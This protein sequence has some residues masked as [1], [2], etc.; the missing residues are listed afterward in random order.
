MTVDPDYPADHSTCRPLPVP[1]CL[2]AA[3]Q[4]DSST[5]PTARLTRRRHVVLR[6]APTGSSFHSRRR[7]L[8]PE[9]HS[10]GEERARSCSSAVPSAPLPRR[11]TRVSCPI[12][13]AA[14]TARPR[15]PRPPHR[16][17]SAK[18]DP[19][20]GRTSARIP[21]Q[22]APAAPCGR[23]PEQRPARQETKIHTLAVLPR[24]KPSG[25]AMPR[26]PLP[27]R[28]HSRSMDAASRKRSMTRGSATVH[29]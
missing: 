25:T 8:D 27:E 19:K 29:T 23:H 26:G 15:P 18:P 16:P 17:V 5:Q 2:F 11:P 10:D 7:D 21:R 13:A 9:E 22:T 12:A 14:T 3:L 6:R 24:M 4:L 1:R 20:S 28:P